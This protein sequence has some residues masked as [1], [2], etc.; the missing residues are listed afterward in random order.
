MMTAARH[1]LA[2]IALLAGTTAALAQSW[3]ATQYDDGSFFYAA[4][5]AQGLEIGC[6]ERSPRGL[7]PTQTG[8]M[9]P[10]VSPPGQFV[11]YLDQSLLG[12]PDGGLTPRADVVVAANGTGYRLPQVTWNELYGTWELFLGVADPVFGAIAADP[13]IAVHSAGRA[14]RIG[15]ANFAEVLGVTAAYCQRQFAAIG[16]P[17]GA[18]PAVALPAAPSGGTASMRAVAEAHIAR[19]CEGSAVTPP[20][21]F[22]TGNFDDDGAEDVVVLWGKVQCNG[23]YPRPLCGASMCAAD[24]FISAHH[25]APEGSNSLLA[26]SAR[27]VPLSNG[28]DGLATS[29][30]LSMCQDRGGGFCEF[31]WYWDGSDIAMIE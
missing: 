10:A 1:G 6:G 15:T 4:A 16:K 11:L 22:L 7:S 20:D 19:I 28:R 27:I 30:S 25:P 8:N 9:E 14:V 26:G 13:E 18:A 24:V 17:W 12:A 21:A 23:P 29:G 31:F 2:A 5:A 3:E